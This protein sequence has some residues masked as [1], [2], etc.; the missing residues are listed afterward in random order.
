MDVFGIDVACAKISGEVLELS[1][2]SDSLVCDLKRAIADM[3]AS[4]EIQ[5][6]PIC[7]KLMFQ[8][9]A[10]ED[11]ERLR[12]LCEPPAET[13]TKAKLEMTLLLTVD[14]ILATFGL[15]K[16]HLAVAAIKVARTMVACDEQVL[17][18]L[19]HCTPWGLFRGW[20]VRSETTSQCRVEAAKAIS[21]FA[22]S[23]QENAVDALIRCLKS[24]SR[25][26]RDLVIDGLLNVPIEKG[27]L[28]KKLR[29][30]V[31]GLVQHVPIETKL[32][33]Y[34][35]Y[36]DY[37]RIEKWQVLPAVE[38]LGRLSPPGDEDALAVLKKALDLK[39]ELADRRI[40]ARRVV[41][42][43][44]GHV[45]WACPQTARKLV[46]HFV[47]LCSVL[48]VP[49]QIGRFGMVNDP[50][51]HWVTTVPA[52]AQQMCSFEETRL[53]L[54]ESVVDELVSLL[55][56]AGQ[57]YP[58]FRFKIGG[59]RF[60]T[61]GRMP[62]P[63]SVR[64]AAIEL[65][66]AC[67]NESVV[68]KTLPLLQ[69]H[70]DEVRIAAITVLGRRSFNDE[71][72]MAELTNLLHSEAPAV[73]Q[74]AVTALGQVGKGNAQV[75]AT[76]RSCLSHADGW[77]R[78]SAPR[79][80]LNAVGSDVMDELRQLSAQGDVEVA[81]ASLLA[82]PD[83]VRAAAAA[84]EHQEPHIQFVAAKLLLKNH[85]MPTWEIDNSMA[86]LYARLGENL[87]HEPEAPS[88]ETF[89]AV[90]QVVMRR[91]ISETK[92]ICIGFLY[93]LGVRL[94][95]REAINLLQEL[96]DEKLW[97]PVAEAQE[98]L[99]LLR[100][101]PKPKLRKTIK[102]KWVSSMLSLDRDDDLPVPSSLEEDSSTFWD[103]YRVE[104]FSAHINEHDVLE[105]GDA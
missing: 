74:E 99:R 41:L 13:G 17:S 37:Y 98:A 26:I 62:N 79:A 65:L 80:L 50:H 100:E 39:Y 102:A 92:Q 68:E 30:A 28:R 90:K 70:W 57:T 35:H 75:I 52:V 14:S 88:A 34:D 19:Y 76:L 15:A 96:L 5:F 3:A 4:D 10:L 56:H 66:S 77:V 73:A 63:A 86:A 85:G 16:P 58:R 23:G 83:D 47:K 45:G 40:L 61:R 67:A 97:H 59:S 42:S 27:Q 33:K 48:M 78:R 38:I 94:Q 1:L 32:G 44:L 53:E 91:E 11:T 22:Q 69:H 43:S 104:D 105:T 89:A 49:L 12:M 103:A 18:A 6:H 71:V 87:K 93:D 60:A 9:R 36:E 64:R 29:L 72:V 2:D 84:L 31:D 54:P 21:S 82:L 20:L 95:H 24:P 55:S 7:Q 51:D 46:Q 8:G 25:Q 81:E 101:R